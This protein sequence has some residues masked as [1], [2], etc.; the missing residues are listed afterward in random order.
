MKEI[1][2]K[3]K[4]LLALLAANVAI[5]GALWAT[6]EP[7]L[8]TF[9]TTKSI[10]LGLYRL[11]SSETDPLAV[12]CATGDQFALARARGYLAH[13]HSCPNDFIP[14]I[15]PIVARPGDTVTVSAGGIAVNGTTLPNS[16]AEDF[17]HLHRPMKPW[18]TGTYHVMQDTVWVVSSYNEH[19]FDSRYFGP[20]SISLIQ[21]Y[22]H[23]IWQ[24]NK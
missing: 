13:S 16:R 17:D 2:R 19:S 24:V 23:A 22:A 21:H 1:T 5:L 14:M 18:P 6:G 15:K 11:T 4:I 8:F 3:K 20:I 7:E 10:P 12:F 9:N